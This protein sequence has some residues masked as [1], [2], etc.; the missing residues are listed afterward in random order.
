M[1]DWS[2]YCSDKLKLGQDP[3]LSPVRLIWILSWQ[4]KARTRSCFESSPVRLIWILSWQAKART[5]SCFESSP[6]RLI[7]IL[8]WQAKART[9][10]SSVSSVKSS[11]KLHSSSES[12]TPISL[13]IGLAWK[14]YLKSVLRFHYICFSTLCKQQVMT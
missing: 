9:R 7:W 3:A 13:K 14:T 4:A 10:S 6:V 1:L 12:W 2:E 5:R 11:F 8:S